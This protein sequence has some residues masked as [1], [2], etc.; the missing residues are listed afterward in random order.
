[1]GWEGR[2]REPTLEQQIQDIAAAARELMDR[3]TGG[4]AASASYVCIVCQNDGQFADVCEAASKRGAVIMSTPSGP[5]FEIAPLPSA[6]G[7]VRILKVRRFDSARPE[8]GDAD[9]DLSDYAEF[10]RT[11]LGRPGFTLVPGDG[12][13]RIKLAEIGTDVHVFFSSPTISQQ[14]GIA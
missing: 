3:S 9:F 10:K 11:H 6:A 13:E 12:H 4:V 5:I 2:H 7:E 14:F 1:V 8:V